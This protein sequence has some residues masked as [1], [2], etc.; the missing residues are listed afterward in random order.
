ML[1]K[2]G[3]KFLFSSV[4]IANITVYKNNLSFCNTDEFIIIK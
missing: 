3:I 1:R 2:L 4:F